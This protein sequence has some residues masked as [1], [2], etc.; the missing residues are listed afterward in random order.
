MDTF[1]RESLVE[2]QGPK[3]RV[4]IQSIR[5]AVQSDRLATGARL[6]PVRDLAHRLG[7]TPGTVAR[8]YRLGVSEGLLEAQV[9][10]GTFVAGRSAPVSEPPLHEAHAADEIDLRPVRL[11]DLGQAGQITDA[12]REIA[13]RSAALVDYPD[14]T[15]DSA[16]RVALAT[17]ASGAQTGPLTG[18]DMV[19]GLGA[20]NV[21]FLLLQH[22]LR[23]PEPVILTEE[24]TYP[25]FRHSA[26]LLRARLVGVAMDADGLRPDALLAAARQE[27]AQV[28][29]TTPSL[30]SPTGTRTSY[31]RRLELSEVIRHTR[32]QVIE[33]ETH[34]ITPMSQPGYRVLCPDQGW[35]VGGL[36]KIYSP[37]LRLGYAAAPE[38]QGGYARQVAM[39][40]FYG[41]PPLMTELALM[42]LKSGALET[43]RAQVRDEVAVRAAEAAAILGHRDIT[44]APEAPFVWLRL[45]GGWRM[46]A[47]QAACRARGVLL[48][49]ADVFAVPGGAVPDAVR[50]SLNL[51]LPRGRVIEGLRRIDEILNAP[52]PVEEI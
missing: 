33:D 32:L 39:S 37:G 51:Q 40:N 30:H 48:R 5:S 15:S 11:A 12:L 35:H 34:L 43:T 45:P 17:W 14:E 29:I 13:G 4:L 52:P 10:R 46:A 42:L 26:R 6:P 47:F 41:L 16:L 19:L 23:G 2:G 25:G 38:G 1:W 8:A 49:G 9:G 27:G 31:A 24:L 20:Q 18:A 21:V 3:Y 44:A 22:M 28:L 36:S 50:L 7:V